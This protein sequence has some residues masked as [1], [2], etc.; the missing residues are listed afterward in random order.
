[1]RR[2]VFRSNRS[3][4]N[5]FD[6]RF[7]SFDGGPAE[8]A[9]QPVSQ[10]DSEEKEDCS[11]RQCPARTEMYLIDT[12]STKK[13]IPF[14]L[15]ADF[16]FCLRFLA[17]LSLLV[18]SLPPAVLPSD[19][20]TTTRESPRQQVLAGRPRCSGRDFDEIS[21][22]PGQFHLGQAELLADPVKLSPV[23]VRHAKP[24]RRDCPQELHAQ[25]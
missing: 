21:K 10:R 6:C 5:R 4:F 17:L 3:L 22:P 18:R 25:P 23:H 16:S 13:V 15:I 2:R 14:H 9:R 7:R 8:H 24:P 1:M 19:P 11:Y 12:R 20:G